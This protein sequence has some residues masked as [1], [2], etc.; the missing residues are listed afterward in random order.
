MA[1]NLFEQFLDFAASKLAGPISQ[2]GIYRD[3][4]SELTGVAKYL[5]QQ[6]QAVQAQEAAA[7]PAASGVEKYLA[8]Q[9]ALTAKDTVS[10]PVQETVQEPL[11]G[12]AKYLA[13]QYKAAKPAAKPEKA[14]AP[15]P[16]PE[17]KTGVAKYLA[18]QFKPSITVAAKPAPAPEPTSKVA[19]Y[20]AEQEKASASPTAK[21]AV[22]PAPA[23]TKAQ[24]N[25]THESDTA[26][27]A[28]SVIRINDDKRCQ[29]KTS[30]GTQCKN[31]A[32][33]GHIQ[34][35]INKQRYMF[36]VCSQHHNDSFKPFEPLLNQ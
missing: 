22:K 31:T 11:T 5:A 18:G 28:S 24:A 7:A 19:K 15:E 12:V 3:E 23:T 32:N 9:A 8:R 17:P 20:L 30:K 14:K 2:E 29:A 21:P 35:T 26:K 6:E 13:G 36:S 4:S 1:K 33:L 10:T 16:A 34:R 25:P 27:P